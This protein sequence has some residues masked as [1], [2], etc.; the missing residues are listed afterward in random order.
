[1]SKRSLLTEGKWWCRV[2]SRSPRMQDGSARSPS[3]QRSPG[4]LL[5]LRISY[6]SFLLLAEHW[7]SS[8]GQERSMPFSERCLKNWEVDPGLRSEEHTSEL[9]SRGHLVCR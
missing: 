6:F 8:E 4:R 1:M 3:L 2:H 9:Q 5:L 7:R